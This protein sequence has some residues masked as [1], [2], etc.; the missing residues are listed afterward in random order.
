MK[1]CMKKIL[2]RKENAKLT[3]ELIQHIR[4]NNKPLW[5]KMKEYVPTLESNGRYESLM[6]GH[7]IRVMG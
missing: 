2:E 6:Q 7:K 4:E 3:R 5:V 1:E